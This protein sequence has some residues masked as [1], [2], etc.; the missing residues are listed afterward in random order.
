MDYD[1]VVGADQNIQLQPIHTDL[2]RPG[3]ASH[4]V[5]WCEPSSAA[6]TMN[7]RG[8]QKIIKPIEL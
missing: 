3:K 8:S 5:L 4:R 7:D 2:P 1:P 6:M